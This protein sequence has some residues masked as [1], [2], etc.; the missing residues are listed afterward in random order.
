MKMKI[1]DTIYRAPLPLLVETEMVGKYARE[2]VHT[3]HI[4]GFRGTRK[5]MIWHLKVEHR[6]EL[7]VA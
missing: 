4:H 2:R 3:C 6:K 1:G 7:E 5:E